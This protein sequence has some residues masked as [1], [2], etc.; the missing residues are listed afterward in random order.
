MEVDLPSLFAGRRDQV[1]QAVSSLH[2]H[3][4]VPIIFG[5]RGLGKSSLAV[6]LQRIALG[7]LDLLAQFDREDLGFADDET[8]LALAKVHDEM[9]RAYRAA[10]WATAA[11]KLAWCREHGGGL[12]LT[13]LYDIYAERLASHPVVT[14][15][16]QWD[17]IYEALEK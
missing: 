3:G 2:T 6:Q 15:A 17:G 10:D 13:K 8:F 16:T 1:I 12:P 7:D 14:D 5:D 4:E 11:E 9:I